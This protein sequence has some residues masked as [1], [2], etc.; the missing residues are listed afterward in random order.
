MCGMDCNS[1]LVLCRCREDSVFR[2]LLLSTVD[3]KF[4]G[5]WKD[6]VLMNI[7]ASDVGC[8][9]L[10]A[11]NVLID[12]RWCVFLLVFTIKS[13]IHC[14]ER[15]ECLCLK[16]VSHGDFAGSLPWWLKH[17]WNPIWGSWNY[18]IGLSLRQFTAGGVEMSRFVS[19]S[20]W[21]LERSQFQCKHTR[22]LK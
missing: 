9:D 17:C 1:V 10:W 15:F 6:W 20:T 5:S 12:C 7:A 18:W 21:G 2:L 4:L 11:W 14:V 3:V 13:E 8:V 22:V 16:V 19:E